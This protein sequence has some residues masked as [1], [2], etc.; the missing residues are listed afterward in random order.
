MRPGLKFGDLSF[1]DERQR[2]GF[3]SVTLST[4]DESESW[5]QSMSSN[6]ALALL[7]WLHVLFGD[8]P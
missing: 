2:A 8:N 3:I 4:P 1:D 6:E 7:G 5:G